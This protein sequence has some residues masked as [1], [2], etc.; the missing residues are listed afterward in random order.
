MSGA[1]PFRR[2][3]LDAA[4]AARLLAARGARTRGGPFWLLLRLEPPLADTRAG[5]ASWRR[6]R[7]PTLL[8]ALRAADA[9]ARDP[10][11]AGVVVRL[12]GAP[13]SWSAAESL[14]RALDAVRAAGKPVV[15]YGERIGQPEYLVAGGAGRLW[16]PETGSLALVG[17]RSEGV[18]L[19]ELLDRIDVR[20]DVVRVGSHKTAAE[21]L[22]RRGMSP[23]SREQIGAY[24]DEVYATLVDAI[25]RGRK[26]APDAV[27]AAIDAGPYG[28]RRACEAGLA[29][30]C[31]YP[32]ELEGALVELAPTTAGSPARSGAVRAR[33]DD[34]VTYDGL[35]AGD[36]GWRP[37]ARDLPHVA[38]LAASGAIHRRAPL[39]G[40]SAESWPPLLRRLREDAAVR[41]VV[42]RI[43][44]PGGDALASDLLWRAL[45]VLREEKPVVVSM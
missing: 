17:L 25:T 9:A 10:Q 33:L 39:G 1:G 18:Y 42:L 19:K 4:R 45:R 24:V 16:L 3:A 32:D 21:T 37:L 2:L 27:R 36:P 12:A 23:E 28:A 43:T 15:A 26:L 29:D 38:F 22:T 20:A 13:A 44:S 11:V 34:A 41:A 6:P 35:R 40:I 8:E 7:G 30:G 5:A 14:R 31:R